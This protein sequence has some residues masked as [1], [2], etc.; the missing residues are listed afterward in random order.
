[1]TVKTNKDFRE[2]A[3]E[4]LASWHKS[5]GIYNFP[6]RL[7]IST[8]EKKFREIS[9]RLPDGVS[10]KEA[11]PR[12][13]I[14]NLDKIYGMDQKV[15]G[16]AITYNV[17]LPSLGEKV[18]GQT[19]VRFNLYMGVVGL[20]K[21]KNYFVAVEHDN[22]PHQR[23]LIS[24]AR[25]FGVKETN[26]LA[27]IANTLLEKEYPF[28]LDKVSN[29]KVTQLGNTFLNDP[30]SRKEED[31]NLLIELDLKEKISA[32]NDLAEIIDHRNKEMIL[33]HIFTVEELKDIY[34]S[35]KNVNSLDNVIVYDNNKFRDDF[36]FI[37]MSL[38]FNK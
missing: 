22:F 13:F 29:I 32:K 36:S 31:I 14:S 5:H 1:M 6:K 37:I 26:D 34:L 35:Y 15:V 27:E 24:V 16:Y 3:L 38:Y 20:V 17:W 4:K 11:E 9:F 30:T 10:M 8:N 7:G 23:K 33:H 2:T 12:D 19:T 18:P 25:M 28:F 21:V